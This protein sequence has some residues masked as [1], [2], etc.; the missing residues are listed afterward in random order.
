MNEASHELINTDNRSVKLT[1]SCHKSSIVSQVLRQVF[2][3]A[4]NATEL[5]LL[6]SA[7]LSETKDAMVQV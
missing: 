3:I 7:S 2:T 6:N 1:L 4:G 5:N